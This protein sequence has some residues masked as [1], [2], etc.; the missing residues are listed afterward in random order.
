M[1]RPGEAPSAAIV[2]VGTELTT[3]LR[4][5]T[6][7]AAVAAA[8]TGHG[9]RVAETAS[10]PDDRA[11]LARSLGRLTRECDVVVVTGGLGPTH[12][13]VT[14]EAASEALAL[15]LDR[16]ADLAEGLASVARRHHDP[17]AAAHVF[18]QADVLGGADVLPATTG[19]APGQIVPTPGG[20]SLILLPGPPSEMLPMLEV[21]LGRL[22]GTDRAAT[23][24]LA[25]VGLPESDVQVKVERVLARSGWGEGIGFT[26]LARPAEVHAVLTD[27]GAGAETLDAAS[28]AVCVALG[29]A[30]FSSDG[31]T[32]AETVLELARE[33]GETLSTAESCTGGMVAAALT[34]PAGASDVFLGSVVSYS[35]EVKVVVLGV[36]DSLLAQ[37]GAVSEAVVRA[38][39]EGTRRAT[40]S[41]LSV[42]VTGIAGPGGAV[43]GKPV[44]TV[45][46]GVADG[47]GTVAVT[48]RLMGDRAGI[49]TRATITALDL[50]RRRLAGL[51][52]G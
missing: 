1:S 27:E 39:A 8:L 46:F 42:A 48:R 47:S 25:S 36:G 10:L 11:S 15:P 12:D 2:T 9:L 16:D 19:T 21:A 22:P 23:R 13:D 40:G 49:R 6:N 50:L 33:R 30:C 51:P 32:L 5:D 14:R 41:S 26:V 17:E 24:V 20:G 34:E 37:H 44:G 43:P 35:N 38:M 45:W 29:D 3:G 7:T 18:R 4:L 52:V 28:R 31:S